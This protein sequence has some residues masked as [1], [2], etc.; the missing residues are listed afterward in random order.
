MSDDPDIGL[1]STINLV[2]KTMMKTNEIIKADVFIVPNE[3]FKVSEKTFE[4]VRSD[5]YEIYSATKSAGDFKDQTWVE[6][7]F[8]TRGNDDSNWTDHTI[9][10]FKELRGWK[11]IS[12]YLPKAIFDGHKEGDIITIFLPICKSAELVEDSYVDMRARVKVELCLKQ[13][14]YRY[15]RFGKFEEVLTRV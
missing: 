3:S 15:E 9:D 14:G 1:P 4:W 6:V 11:P 13:Q 8:V 12:H 5:L 7:W 10:G 2:N